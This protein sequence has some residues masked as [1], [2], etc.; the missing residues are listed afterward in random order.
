[1][2]K[3]IVSWIALGLFIGVPVFAGSGV[4]VTV[5]GMVCGFCAQGIKKKFSA[6]AA[7][8]QVNVSLEKHL[9]TLQLKQGQE[10]SDEKITSVLK[11]AGYTVEAIKRN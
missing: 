8:D 1:M 7:V 9:V 5:K 6:D 2:K 4:Q 11:D 3:K 10:L